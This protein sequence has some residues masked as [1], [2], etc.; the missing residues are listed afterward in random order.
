MMINNLS[1]DYFSWKERIDNWSPEITKKI[2]TCLNHLHSQIWAV[3][4]KKYY[5]QQANDWY[6]S[7][8][9]RKYERSEKITIM[10]TQSYISIYHLFYIPLCFKCNCRLHLVDKWKIS[11]ISNLAKLHLVKLSQLRETGFYI[12]TYVLSMWEREK[13]E[14]RGGN[15]EEKQTLLW[16]LLSLIVIHVEGWHWALTRYQSLVP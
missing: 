1:T 2:L 14:K 7:L 5:S 6:S 16:V 13:E 4:Q 9:F 3:Q 8:N 10:L 11:A 15:K 12:I